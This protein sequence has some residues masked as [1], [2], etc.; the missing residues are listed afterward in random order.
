M[1]KL[2]SKQRK[3][4]AFLFLIEIL[5]LVALL[6]CYLYLPDFDSYFYVAC[7][8]LG[9]YLFIDTLFIIAY[10]SAFRKNK[11]NSDLKAASIIGNDINQAYNF[12]ELGLAV[13]D[14]NNNVI[15]VN[16]FMSERF[17]MIVDSNIFSKFPALERL[18]DAAHKAS[19]EHPRVIDNHMTYEVELIEEARL[20]IFKDITDFANIY[21]Y[22]Q[23]QSPVVGYILIDNYADIQM[24][25]GDDSE[26]M[27]MHKDVNDRINKFGSEHNALLRK[28]TEDRYL[29]VMTKE[30]YDKVYANKFSLVSD[31]AKAHPRGFTISMG[32]G[33]GFPDY[34]RLASMASS[35]LD[36]ALSRGGDQVAVDN[37]GQPI[38]FFGGKTDLMP[39]RNRVKTRML[40]NTFFTM[41]KK[42]QNVIIMGHMTA[43]FDAFAS[44]LAVY[45][46]CQ[47]AK[48]DAK[49]CYEDRFVEA[50]CRHAVDV[51]FTREETDEMFVS[52]KEMDS[53][54]NDKTLLVMV[55]HSNPTISIFSEYVRKF[56]NIAI[57]DHHRPGTNI[58]NDTVFEDV[59]TSASSTSEILTSFI[60]YYPND[61]FVDER[62]ATFLLA[63]ISL[64]THFFREHSTNSTFEACAQLKNWNADTM[65]VVDFLR[66]GLEEFTQKIEILATQQCLKPGVMVMT[67]PDDEQVDGVTLSRVADEAVSVDGVQASFCIGRIGDH[68]IKIAARSNGSVNVGILMEKIGDGKRGGGRFVAAA[69]DFPESTVDEVL[70]ELKEVL[71]DYLDDARIN[72]MQAK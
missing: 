33:L 67:A 43:D 69:A 58:V 59:D 5:G 53:Y 31:V 61:I 60:V 62:T 15:W 36:A 12:G 22:N 48:V 70:K 45:E 50:K 35:A 38:A 57:I 9:G 1:N 30:N 21:D 11:T 20:F 23:K 63:G 14:Y 27:E 3:W 64:D 40:A 26:F 46:L 18:K 51:S 47:N 37:H 13:C 25:I 24:N 16:D 71:N 55:D 65:K 6:L 72:N 10:N 29:F 49:I 54:I 2:L 34:G 52:M 39:S 17:P 41:L 42:Y 19:N 44:A 28:I 66:E 7:G 32:I 56:D 8:L 68:N 4:L